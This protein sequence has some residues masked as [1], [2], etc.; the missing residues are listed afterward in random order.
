LGRI[1][2]ALGVPRH[3]A[4]EEG[5]MRAGKIVALVAG[6]LI[7]LIAMALLVPGGVL[8]GLWGTQRDEAGF[9]NTSSHTLTSS[10]YALVTPDVDLN[11]GPAGDWLPTGDRAA[12]RIEATSSGDTPVFVGIGP[13]DKVADY[14]AGVEYDEVTDFGWSSAEVKYRHL[15]GAAPSAPPAEQDFWTV[16]QEGSGGQT[17][18]WDV[19]DG[20][21]TVVVMNADATAPVSAGVSLGGRLDILFPIALG[22]VIGGVILLGVGI[23]LIVL[24]ARRPRTPPYVQGQ[25][26]YPPGGPYPPAGQ[27]PPAGPPPSAEQPPPAG[28]PPQS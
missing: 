2:L 14:L 20:N 10:G 6:I 1:R 24:G 28:A 18:E 21:W 27:Y 8:L 23:L 13:S 19:R 7:V 12:I 4:V 9:F 16:H 11:M 15:D 26:P 17:L 25:M 5:E 3:T 22:I